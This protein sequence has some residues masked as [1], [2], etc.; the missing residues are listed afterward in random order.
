MIRR[1]FLNAV[2]GFVSGLL[3]GNTKGSNTGVKMLP[4]AASIG[5]SPR[6]VSPYLQETRV[7]KQLL[8]D[9]MEHYARLASQHERWPESRG[10]NPYEDM[11]KFERYLKSAADMAAELAPY[12]HPRLAVA[13]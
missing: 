10:K 1:E 4:M 9:M 5:A 8:R 6:M 7:P 11:D 2:V 12:E 13:S 3:I